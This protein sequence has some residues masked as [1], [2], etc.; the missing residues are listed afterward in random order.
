VG[1][2]IDMPV[3]MT[4]DEVAQFLHVHASTVYRMV[5]DRRIPAFKVGSDWRFNMLSIENWMQTME[6]EQAT[7]KEEISTL[8]QQTSPRRPLLSARAPRLRI[9]RNSA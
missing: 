9:S 8:L 1:D 5:K 3:V 2:N 7:K 4:L 6:S